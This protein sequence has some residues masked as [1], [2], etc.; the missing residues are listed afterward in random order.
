MHHFVRLTDFCAEDVM[1]I[2]RTADE[3]NHG[4]HTEFLK[5]KNIVL[6]FPASSIRTRVTF[7]KGIY[8]LGGQS[9][10]FPSEALDKKEDIRDL[11]GYLN[12]WADAVV[13]RHKDIHLLEKMAE[14]LT[15]PLINAMTDENHPCE[16]TADLYALSKIRN[17]FRKDRFLFVGKCGNIGLAWKEIAKV[18]GFSLE[19]CCGKGYE[20]DGIQVH[21]DIETA[22][23]GKDIICTDALPEKD[24]PSFQKCQVTLD[25]MKKA[26]EGA[27]L[28][29][30]PPFYR[31]EEVD[32]QVLESHYFV[33]Y[34]F[35]KSLLE[36]QQAIIV[37]CMK[38]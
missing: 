27:L 15:V 6:F 7:E 9:I 20:I 25:T 17:D 24:L 30:C 2:F 33:G 13:V 34:S 16:V 18:M 21:Y 38:R 19:Q 8:L 28:N 14:Y 26:N 4:M 32:A 35:K 5:G 23:V 36:V 22:V 1:R 11:C 3:I 29:P 10:L 37:D 31:G 12:Q